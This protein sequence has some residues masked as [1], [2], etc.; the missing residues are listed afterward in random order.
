MPFADL[1]PHR[2]EYTAFYFASLDPSHASNWFLRLQQLV[3]GLISLYKPSTSSGGHQA[4]APGKV[5]QGLGSILLKIP[6]TNCGTAPEDKTSAISSLSSSPRLT[7]LPSPASRHPAIQII[8]ADSRP[9]IVFSNCILTPPTPPECTVLQHRKFFGDTCYGINGVFALP[10]A[11]QSPSRAILKST[12]YLR[13][14][15]YLTSSSTSTSICTARFVKYH[16]SAHYLSIRPTVPA[17]QRAHDQTSFC[18]EVPQGHTLLV[19]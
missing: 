18:S 7:S 9:G 12:P 6:C 2:M 1:S 4:E 8:I 5:D 14:F 3:P 15:R 16:T 10:A 11:N 13:F 17:L 19:A